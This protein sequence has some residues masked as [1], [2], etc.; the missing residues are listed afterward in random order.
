MTGDKDYKDVPGELRKRVV[1]IGG[2]KNMASSD[3]NPPPPS[4]VPQCMDEQ[5][6]YLRTDGMQPFQQSIILRLAIAHSHFE[7]VHP[8][9]DGNGRVGRLL[10]PLMM[11]ADGHAPLYLR[12]R[13]HQQAT[14]HRRAKGCA[15]T[16]G[17][18]SARELAKRC[19]HCN[20]H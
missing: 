19:N 7:A 10:I 15:A 4:R 2:G 5:V 18:R 14:I 9:R 3:F 16:V 6:A 17:L 12:L 8:F 1:W 13:P 11:A 20:R